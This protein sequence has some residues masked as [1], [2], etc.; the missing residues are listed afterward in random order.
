MAIN[1]SVKTEINRSQSDTANYIFDAENFVEWIN[2]LNPSTKLSINGPLVKG[3]KINFK[4][5]IAGKTIDKNY[6]VTEIEPRHLI[7]I[8]YPAP[9]DATVTY[10]FSG[11]NADRTLAEIKLESPGVPSFILGPL[12]DSIF[13]FTRKIGYRKALLRLKKVLES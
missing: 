1:I 5:E 11:I 3:A 4:R 8:K 6:E 2:S 9:L 13:I 12:L 10:I 7:K